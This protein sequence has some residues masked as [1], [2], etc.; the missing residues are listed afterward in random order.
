MKNA[1]LIL[2]ITVL[3]ILV[4]S[5]CGDLTQENVTYM[6]VTIGK[7]IWMSENLFI[8]KF[9]NGELIPEA[10]TEEEWKLAG[11]NKQP[12]WCYY[13][14]DTSNGSLYGKLYNWYAV[15]DPRGLAPKGWHI[16][17]DGEWTALT[18]SLGGTYSAGKKL[19][20][21][22]FIDDGH[23][24]Y[25]SDDAQGFKFVDGSQIISKEN[26]KVKANCNNESGF[27]GLPGGIRNKDGQFYNIGPVGH[28]WSSTDK[29]TTTAWCRSIQN[30]DDY[31]LVNYI[32]EN[33]GLSVRCIKD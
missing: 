19:K 17:S 24:Y 14:N 18:N 4:F 23:K 10:K 13:D 32:E 22:K 6:E 12:A 29:G 27:S 9:R 21:K 28:W 15:N 20:S 16:P 5:R 11:I 26:W 31:L 3:T 33:Y 8:D 2:T 25:V 7:Q 1:R 30:D